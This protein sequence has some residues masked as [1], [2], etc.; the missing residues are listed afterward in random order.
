MTYTQQWRFADKEMKRE[1]TR[2]ASVLQEYLGWSAVIEILEDFF[3]IVVAK[4]TLRR[5]IA[6]QRGQ[7]FD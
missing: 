6:H 1:A 5:A 2:L 7:L 3:K 4:T